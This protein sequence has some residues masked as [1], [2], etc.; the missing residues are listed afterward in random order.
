[1][2]ELPTWACELFR[3]CG[4]GVRWITED[5][6]R[7]ALARLSGALP[8]RDLARFRNKLIPAGQLAG[9]R[10]V[11]GYGRLV[12]ITGRGFTTADVVAMLADGGRWPWEPGGTA[13]RGVAGPDD[14]ARLAA[15]RRCVELDGTALR[16]RIAP[17][18]SIPAGSAVIGTELLGDRRAMMRGGVGY[19]LD[20]V[21]HAL[22]CGAWPWEPVWD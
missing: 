12:F 15:I 10:D 6:R 21:A 7:E 19:L 8:R 11:H 22:R 5:E 18:S 17:H 14:V 9:G 4:D 20:D 2:H 3:T 16:W 13:V 1:M